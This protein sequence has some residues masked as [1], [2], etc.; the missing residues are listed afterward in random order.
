MSV[1]NLK[2]NEEVVEYDMSVIAGVDIRTLQNLR[3]QNLIPRYCFKCVSRGKVNRNEIYV[4]KREKTIKEIERLR[5]EGIVNKRRKG[6]KV[7]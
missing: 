2:R 1:K 5:D 6:K 7:R 4:Y 3:R